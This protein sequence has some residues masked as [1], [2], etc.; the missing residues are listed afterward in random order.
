MEENT[1]L[2][3]MREQLSILKQKLD[4]EQII[5]DR[6]LR[7]SCRAKASTFRRSIM[8]TVVSS[9]FV[10]FMVFASFRP[11]MGF[12]WAFC[13]ATVIMML[14]C[15]FMT[16]WDHRDVGEDSFNGDLLT[17]ARNV[18]ELRRRYKKWIYV[19]IPMVTVWYAWFLWEIWQQTPDPFQFYL[20]FGTTLI[21]GLIGFFIGNSM[22]RKVIR[23]CDDIINQIEG[24]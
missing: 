4:N 20:M 24:V 21:G 9:L 6:L 3:E 22:R 14:F 7:E 23:A 2:D 11:L 19:A 18:R 15:I 5:N 1:N 8:L 17:A 12:S 13:I 10:I 16:Y